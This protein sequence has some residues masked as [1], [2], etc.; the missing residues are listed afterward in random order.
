M[1]S[2]HVL[3]CFPSFASTYDLCFYKHSHSSFGSHTGAKTYVGKNHQNVVTL[4][5]NHIFDVP[6]QIS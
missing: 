3:P 2:H 1:A 5:Q 6:P 4:S